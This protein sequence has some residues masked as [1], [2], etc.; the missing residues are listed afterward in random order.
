MDRCL[1]PARMLLC[2]SAALF[3]LT[4]QQEKAG[5]TELLGRVVNTSSG[6]PVHK[7]TVTLRPLRSAQDKEIIGATDS[8]GKFCFKDVP[9]GDYD[10]AAQK[11][12]FLR[13]KYDS[14]LSLRSGDHVADI[15]LRLTPAAIIRGRVVDEDGEPLAGAEVRPW[16]RE[17]WF[18]SDDFRPYSD[19]QSQTNG[20]G[21]YRL[22]GLPPG[23][24][25]VKA[26]L[27]ASAQ[28]P[29]ET[30]I[31]DSKGAPDPLRLVPTYYPNAL[32]VGE[33]SFVRVSAG[34][35]QDNADIR[36]RRSRTFRLSGRVAG[37]DDRLAPGITI[38][39]SRVEGYASLGVGA[40]PLTSTGE[41]RVDKLIPGSYELALFRSDRTRIRARTRVTITD[42]DLSG[43]ILTPYVPAKVTL[44][45]S[46]GGSGMHAY[47]RKNAVDFT[48]Y[49][50]TVSG[51]CVF[52]D[53][54]P[55]KYSL[56]IAG[57]E[58]SYVQSIRCGDDRLNDRA[59]HISGGELTF[60]VTLGQ[61]TAIINGQVT[62]RDSSAP[63]LR[64]VTVTVLNGDEIP[65]QL[66]MCAADQRGHFSLTRM[67]PGR[68]R[69]FAVEDAEYA[70][71][72]NPD[73]VRELES[74]GTEIEL[75]DGASPQ[76]RLTAITKPELAAVR[77]KL[78]LD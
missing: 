1:C 34:E 22:D 55:G 29:I 15:A 39:I 6:E 69:I 57:S 36:M 2:A 54:E 45:V 23:A 61:A 59:L 62:G 42:A 20:A 63:P 21:E 65:D 38:G 48:A 78:G 30:K 25:L 13:T 64:I 52:S 53:V 71:W 46:G 44:R 70:Q 73:L 27:S 67:R 17:N 11:N 14:T 31:V 9:P 74:K 68:Y 66:L 24:Y 49:C 28:A 37:L 35:S 56:S 19:V 26:T 47:L 32:T 50:R 76:V 41:F 8:E 60:D 58:N 40:A 18:G 3:V 51:E 43:V 16:R 7:A 72:T 77:K 12:G 10:L 75:Q 33:A 4:A 5:T